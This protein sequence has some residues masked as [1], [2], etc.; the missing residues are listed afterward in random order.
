MRAGIDSA[1]MSLKRFWDEQAEDWSR[2]TRT[3]G[4]DAYHERFNLPAFLELVPPPGWRRTLDVGCGEG[5]VGAE[6]TRLGHDVVGVDSSPRM[7][8]LARQRHEAHVVDAVRLPFDDGDFDLVIAYMSVMNFDDPEAV[9]LEVGRVLA[10]GGRF[11]VA[12]VHPLDG[13][14]AFDGRGADAEFVIHGSYFEPQPKLWRSD[15]DGI[16]V[17]FYDRALPL[18]RLFRAHEE[19][20]LLVE[21]V[22]EPR[23]SSKFIREQPVAARRRRVPLFLH[24]RS[25]KA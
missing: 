25:V 5:R 21:A 15:R 12:V 10:P 2:F 11:C 24:L 17:T 7:V 4:H 16:Q 22:R 18:E 13:A 6:L 3:P 19:A 8:E 23:P 9:V 1:A 20:G 14:G